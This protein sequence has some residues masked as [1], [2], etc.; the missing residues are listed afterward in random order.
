MSL[1]YRLLYLLLVVV[2]LLRL[3]SFGGCC[4]Q[5]DGHAQNGFRMEKQN[6]DGKQ[7]GEANAICWARA[8]VVFAALLTVAM[9]ATP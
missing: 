3:L 8:V 7:R 1:L 2:R 5:A 6:Q 4:Q 9:R